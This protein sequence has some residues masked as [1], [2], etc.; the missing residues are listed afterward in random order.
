MEDTTVDSNT[1]AVIETVLN[2]L[3]LQVLPEDKHLKAHIRYLDSDLLRIVVKIFKGCFR[4]GVNIIAS[5]KCNSLL[6]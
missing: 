6:N 4:R 1:N 5:V 2:W 3:N